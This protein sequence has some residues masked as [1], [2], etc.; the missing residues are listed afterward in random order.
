MTDFTQTEMGLDFTQTETEN[1][2]LEFGE[3]GRETCPRPCR[4]RAARRE[5]Y[6][7]VQFSI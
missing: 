4:R 6:R 2:D 1:I 5:L 7:E 3:W